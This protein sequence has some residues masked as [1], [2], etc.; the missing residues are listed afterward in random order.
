MLKD[1][2]VTPVIVVLANG[3]MNQLSDSAANITH[4]QF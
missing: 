4:S 3:V 1:F 2:L